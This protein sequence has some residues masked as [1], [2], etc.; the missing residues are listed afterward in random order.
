MEPDSA[1]EGHHDTVWSGQ[2]CNPHSPC[3]YGWGLLP[4]I[5]QDSHDFISRVCLLGR[6]IFTGTSLVHL[7]AI[8]AHRCHVISVFVESYDEELRLLHHNG[9]IW[10]DLGLLESGHSCINSLSRK[11]EAAMKV[12]ERG[13]FWRPGPDRFGL[14]RY[15]TVLSW[16]RLSWLQATTVMDLRNWRVCPKFK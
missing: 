12:R 7:S 15:P 5:R 8:I 11:Q 14:S 9:M 4:F 13:P 1:N 3:P 2:G 6:W 10:G 16:P